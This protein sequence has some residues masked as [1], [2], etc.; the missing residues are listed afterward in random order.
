VHAPLSSKPA[1][2]K[3]LTLERMFAIAVAAPGPRIIAGD[4]NTPQYESREGQISTFARDRAGLLRAD[5]GER[6]DRAELGLIA[7]L[8][9]AGWTDAFRSLHG[10]MRRDRSWTYPSRPF[11]Y[12]LDHILASPEFTA[13]ACDYLHDWREEGLSDHSPVWAELVRA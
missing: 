8:P 5:R 6:H 7:G 11:G 9:A 1:L 10:Y 4:L 2:D 12:R 3:V 13:V